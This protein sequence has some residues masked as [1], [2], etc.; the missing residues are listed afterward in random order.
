MPTFAYNA[1][2][3]TR[4]GASNYGK[5]RLSVNETSP[6]AN[7][8]YF[9]FEIT[10]PT[11]AIIKPMPSPF[12]TGT[13]PPAAPDAIG[14]SLVSTLTNIPL[15][16]NGA[17]LQGT[18]TFRVIALYETSSGSGVYTSSTETVRYAFT[19][20]EISQFK[21][22]MRVE[23]AYATAK[24]TLTDLTYLVGLTSVSR[25]MSIIPPT[26]PTVSLSGGTTS[27]T[28]LVYTFTYTGVRYVAQLVTD[29]TFTTVSG[30]F[31]FDHQLRIQQNSYIDINA[32]VLSDLRAQ[33][34]AVLVGLEEEMCGSLDC[35][36]KTTLR[37]MKIIRL[38]QNIQFAYFEG[39]ESVVST[40]LV[41]LYALLDITPPTTIIA[42]YTPYLT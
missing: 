32:L 10:S 17:F 31:T 26:I 9:G 30:T 14:T 27:G 33:A 29:A 40:D 13:I 11:G 37:Y 25:T 12:S 20:V 6:N 35:D 28:S 41:E 42:P 4:V 34:N 24:I 18:Y 21:A 5:I 3:Y 38:L 16:S 2:F 36:C 7:P 23:V 39:T 1:T 8:T 15:D 22:N 19:P